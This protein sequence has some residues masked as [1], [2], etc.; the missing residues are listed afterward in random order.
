MTSKFYTVV[1]DYCATGEGRQLRAWLGY[2]EDAKGALDEFS[3]EFDPYFAQGADVFE[4]FE[5]EHYVIKFLYSK[6]A[7]KFISDNMGKCMFKSSAEF[8]YNFA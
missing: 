6:K 5:A 3:E 1:G 4:G 2:A 8:Y 7:R